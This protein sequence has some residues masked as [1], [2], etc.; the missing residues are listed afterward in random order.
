MVFF[1]HFLSLQFRKTNILCALVLMLL[2]ILL[3]PVLGIVTPQHFGKAGPVIAAIALV[4]ILFESGVSL[5]LGML[6]KS[7]AWRN[8]PAPQSSFVAVSR[9]R[10]WNS[11]TFVASTCAASSAHS[12]R[13]E[14]R[15]RSR[16]PR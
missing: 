15:S 4:V 11:G 12:A 6:D 5:N 10:R 7:R 3:G 14:S 13:K 8:R 9:R 1:A 2:G 16:M